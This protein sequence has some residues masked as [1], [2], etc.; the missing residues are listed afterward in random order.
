MFQDEY[1]CQTCK[2]SFLKTLTPSEYVEGT[3]VC[4]HCGSEDVEQ[5]IPASYPISSRESA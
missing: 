2:R 5:R 4:P 3:I 1:F